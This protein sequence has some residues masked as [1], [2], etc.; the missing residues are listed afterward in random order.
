[1]ITR[2]ANKV[3]LVDEVGGNLA[4][5]DFAKDGVAAR[6][7][8]LSTCCLVAHPT[9]MRQ[10]RLR[11]Y[12]GRPAGEPVCGATWKVPRQRFGPL[13]VAKVC[14]ACSLQARPSRRADMAGYFEIVYDDGDQYKGEWNADGKVPASISIGLHCS[15]DFQREGYGILMFADGTRYSGMFANGLC[16]GLG[17]LTFPGRPLTLFKTR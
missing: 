12:L 7:R 9:T 13:F 11:V 14:F 3:V 15:A 6:G 16:H 1:M 2:Q 17:T 10:R 4:A 8:Y 5:D